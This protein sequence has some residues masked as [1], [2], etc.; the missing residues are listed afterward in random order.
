MAQVA[1]AAAGTLSESFEDLVKGTLLDLV[2][3]LK[4]VGLGYDPS[5]A[6]A[7]SALVQEQSGKDLVAALSDENS[8]L[9]RAIP[10]DVLSKSEQGQMFLSGLSL[11]QPKLKPG[12]DSMAPIS[13]LLLEL[14]GVL[15]GAQ[16]GDKVLG[17]IAQE[18]FESDG[19]CRLRNANP[20]MKGKMTGTVSSVMNV[21]CEMFSTATNV[22][23]RKMASGTLDSEAI[24]KKVN[25][26][27]QVCRDKDAALR[28]Q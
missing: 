7:L 6:S 25:H 21:F 17:D 27:R 11:V 18:V 23:E 24:K 19:L 26:I 22:I 28:E 13:R 9:C 1:T 5:H 10:I 4:I 15:P 16:R 3:V 8:E 20:N 12:A 14:T 2:K